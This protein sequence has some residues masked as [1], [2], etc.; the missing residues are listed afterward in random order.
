MTEEGPVH[1]SKDDIDEPLEKD[2]QTRKMEWTFC[3]QEIKRGFRSQ[4]ELTTP[5]GVR[6]G[7]CQVV[8]S[9]MN[10]QVL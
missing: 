10:R 9:L 3:G 5:W 7:E 4:K 2:Q 6:D 1:N 8:S